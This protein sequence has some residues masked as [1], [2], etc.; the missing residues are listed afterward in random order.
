MEKTD[1]PT[2]ARK[3]LPFLKDL[4]K[5][6]SGTSVV[7]GAPSPHGLNST[8]HSGTLANSQAPQF[9]LTNGTRPLTGNLSVSAGV[10]IDGVDLSG[11]VAD[12]NAH[13][14]AVTLASPSGLQLTGQQLQLDDAIA[15]GGLTISGKVLAV[16]AGNGLTVNANDVA[17]TTPGTLT[18]SSANN[19]AG[20]HT[21][22]ITSSA[23]PGAAA[24]LLASNASG[25]LQLT[26]LGLGVAPTVPL[27]ARATTEQLRLDYDVS[28][29][30]S[31]TVGS[32]GNL[33]V[34]PTG[35]FVFDPAGNDVLPNTNY[36]LN[37]GA[38][39][40]KYLT[41][42]AAELW[43][44][45]L[46]AQD[47]LATIGGRIVVAPTSTLIADA[48]SGAT[49][50]DVKHNL[51]SNGDRAWLQANGKLEFMAITSSAT[52][53][54]G[55]Y[56]YNVTRNLDGTG[57][58]D[59]YAG[60][61]VVNTGQTTSGIIDM[62]SLESVHG[63]VFDYIYNYDFSA[64]TYSA[65]FAESS[66]FQVFVSS[67]AVNDMIYLGLASTTWQNAFFPIAVAGVYTMTISWEY[68]NGTVWATLLAGPPD[69]TTTG[70]QGLSF[71]A[72][73]SW[74]TTSVNG[75][76]AY[77]V[78]GRITAFTSLTT[79][80]Q[81]GGKRVIREKSQWGPT[82][83]GWVR[84]SSTFNDLVE[85][86]AIGNLN[87]LYGYGSDTYGAGLG[88]YGSST[89]NYLTADPTNGI[90]FFTGS[91]V[92][93]QL[94]TSVWTLG[95]TTAD[96]VR[97][98]SS[99][100]QLK[101]S[102]VVK[103]DAQTDGDLFI[104]ANVANAADTYFSI[105]ANAQTYNAESMSAGDMLIG[106]NSA[107]KANILWDKSEG[108]LKFR[109]GTSTRFYV[110]TDGALVFIEGG[111]YL[112]FTDGTYPGASLLTTYS[113]AQR[114]VFMLGNPKQTAGESVLAYF[115]ANKTAATAGSEFTG[116]RAF[117]DYATVGNDYLVLEAG[118]VDGLRVA[119]TG[120]VYLGDTAN[121]NMTV[122]LTINQGAN[123]NEILALKSSDVAHGITTFAET[124]T[125]G[126]L[127]KHNAGE[128]GVRVWGFS[129]G[130][131]A[132]ALY[133]MATT[134]DTG[135]STT[136]NANVI[137]RASLKSGTTE[138]AHGA[139][140]NLFAVRSAGNNRFIVDQE[141]DIHMDATSN[142]NA[143]DD[144]NDIALLAGV[145]EA[146]NPGLRLA[147]FVEEA[148]P[149]LERTGVV[150]YNPDG[151]HFIS[152]KKL[153]AL[154]I[155][156]MRQLHQRIEYLEKELEALR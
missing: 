105:F 129:E 67:P 57:P 35:D 48:S 135:K 150:S 103:F 69:F 2:L 143:W 3:L 100:V 32:G 101:D 22:A 106:D 24:S 122:G 132:A 75:Q 102:S 63:R 52:A 108:R 117:L 4:L 47:T 21:H 18:V 104:G 58:N 95:V 28:N 41:L 56:R 97:I 99:G 120:S 19:A 91:T 87:G 77:W 138:T 15:G 65:N 107:S 123:D 79:H 76:T 62:Y 119:Q 110:D 74:A 53:I 36:D 29:Y 131:I 43:V 149:V 154:E 78:R 38:L 42:H 17:L 88:K 61:A 31:F 152:L 92:Q 25:Y 37:L 82:I 68:W 13:H 34:A 156:A 60:D 113:G 145:R 127:Q 16:G 8:H 71:T 96:H 115:G 140:A 90:R 153:H 27:Q 139:N 81:T 144:H 80:P 147:E 128:G 94:S 72:P 118:G 142:I 40:K 111:N 14:N 134:E 126:T 85:H 89:E 20:N 146:M 11:H 93:A 98:T 49:S 112:Y 55:G 64:T 84:G 50:V 130:S 1:L 70:T 86:W 151:H 137:V 45:T 141:G 44:E 116:L 54:T 23:N 83:V 114:N 33:T 155:D 136:A 133:G 39:N 6:S 59:W 148:R 73:G 125:F 9:L 30:A 124:D 12:P 7:G 26:R 10:T 121:A 109:G 66:N 5:T 51:F 46:V